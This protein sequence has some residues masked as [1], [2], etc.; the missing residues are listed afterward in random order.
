VI[1][2]LLKYRLLIFILCG[3]G[4]P[5]ILPGQKLYPAETVDLFSDRSVYFAGEN[6]FYAGILNTEISQ[7][8]LIE[9]VYVELIAP[10]GQKISHAKL[11]LSEKRF[12]GILTVPG[13]VLSGYY[14]LRAYTK[15]MRNGIPSDYAYVRLKIINYLTD[16]LL[17]VNDSLID[18][19][20]I[21]KT[22]LDDFKPWFNLDKEKYHP[23]EKLFIVGDSSSISAFSTI[24]LSIIPTI[25][26]PFEKI[27][28]SNKSSGYSQLSYYPETR[29]LTISGKVVSK[30][31]H[32]PLPYHKVNLHFGREKDFISVLSDTSGNFFIA[33]PER[34]GNQEVFVIASSSDSTEVE[35]LIDQ[36]FC[37]KK[38][39]LKVPQFSINKQDNLQLLQMAQFA[40]LRDVY[41][42]PDSSKS[43]LMPTIPFYGSPYKTIDF[44]EF[45]PMDS[46]AQYITDI[47]SWVKVKGSKGNRKLYLSGPQPDLLYYE[48]LILI[49][50]IPV[51]DAERILAI[52]TARIKK[53]EVVINPYF[54]GGIIYGGILSIISRKNDFAG[55]D[56]PTSGMYINFDFFSP[57]YLNKM[58]KTD[59]PFKNT[60]AWIPDLKPKTLNQPLEFIAPQLKGEYLILLQA[61]DKH[62]VKSSNYKIFTV[63]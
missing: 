28:S 32:I 29:G 54:H 53:F 6:V 22:G 42:I 3:F 23:G 25:A 12:N 9:V 27:S 46:L 18:F 19:S 17:E 60:F 13:D 61:I 38:V 24:S 50:W 63:E 56:F 8:R 26:K 39:K 51:D 55:I 58:V 37:N 2:D 31:N 62:G 43:D 59:V 44:D 20:L 47:S 52:N 5:H 34:Y 30:Q 10:N 4:L 21:E 15:W 49:D 14:F 35:V 16:E 48:P 41:Q 40:Q 36:D 11:K 45:V 7:N 57:L 33:L 1:K